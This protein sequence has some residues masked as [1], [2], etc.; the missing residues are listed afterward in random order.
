MDGILGFKRKYQSGVGKNQLQDATAEQKNRRFLK[1][2]K[3]HGKR[4]Y[5]RASFIS[6]NRDRAESPVSMVE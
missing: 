1:I 5:Q 2:P 6:S 3:C 4:K